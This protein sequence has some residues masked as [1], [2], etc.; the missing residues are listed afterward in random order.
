MRIGV[1]PQRL[2]FR[3]RRPPPPEPKC[4]GIRPARFLVT[5]I[6]WLACGAAA[7]AQ[8]VLPAT[9]L[10]VDTRV[11]DLRGYF[12]QAFGGGVPEATAH[13]WTYSAGVNVS[14]T[15][16]TDVPI[17]SS[18]NGRQS[19][20]LITQI[21]PSFSVSGDSSRLSGSLFYGPSLN[22]YAYHGNQNSIGQSLNASAT[23]VVVP[24]FFYID[25]R[26]FAGEQ[27]ISGYNGPAG[28]T[29]VSSSN[30]A[31]TTS[32]S[33]S[34]SLRHSFG[35]VANA[36]LSYTLSRTAYDANNSVPT[37]TAQ[38][39]N[40][41]V[42]S[43]SVSASLTTGSDFGQFNDAVAAQ[44]SQS[45]GTG[46]LQGAT[47]T[48]LTDTASY[49]L[50][51]SLSIN[52]SIGY[53]D[54]SYGGAGSYA[55]NGVTWSGGL[56]WTPN[57]DSSVSIGYGHQQGN[58]SFYLNATY[59]ATASTRIFARYSQGIGTQS[60]NLQAAVASSTVNSSGVTVDRTTNIPVVLNNNFFVIQTGVFRTTSA[61]ISGVLVWPKDLFTVSLDHEETTQ[62][63]NG[64]A[65]IPGSSSSSTGTY[66]SGSWSHDLSEDL[67][68]NAIV[69]YGTNT[70][71]NS[72]TGTANSNQ[73]S[74]L[75]NFGLT[76][77]IS[78]TLS[79]SAQNTITTGPSGIGTSTGIREI[80]IVS[81]HKT[82]F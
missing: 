65:N 74:L 7:R 45:S 10:D 23:A 42:T 61:S 49:A 37:A 44:A 24:D 16:D 46:A 32:F 18:V 77:S 36:E 3:L 30:E 20:D 56:T 62:L 33:I 80:A 6:I 69:S 4:N 73:G 81:I 48:T 78:D 9:G 26:A 75:V 14:E 19:H 1:T 21:S 63:T 15:Y 12:S 71:T 41:N 47:S 8:G 29:D 79:L 53:E 2:A 60:Q 31:L 70:G 11:G 50:S 43:Q 64:V 38:A 54:Y 76:Y 5:G 51:R 55:T 35:S 72:V 39:V 68:A 52:G 58:S 57:P 13:G 67:H 40:Q 25:L 27:S 22:I 66:L 59:A 34:P 28:T 17:S 82:F